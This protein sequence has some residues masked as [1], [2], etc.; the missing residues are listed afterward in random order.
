MKRG[1]FWGGGEY[2]VGDGGGRDIGGW[3]GGLDEGEVEGRGGIG[4]KVDGIGGWG[5]EEEKVDGVGV[6]VGMEKGDGWC[7]I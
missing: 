6:V 4:V 3:S 7:D 2:G 5:D 1:V